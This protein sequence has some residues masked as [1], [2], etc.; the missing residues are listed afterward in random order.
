M[1]SSHARSSMFTL[2]RDITPNYAPWPLNSSFSWMERSADH[3]ILTRFE[4]QD[5][6][7]SSLGRPG[8]IDYHGNPLKR[9][10]RT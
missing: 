1:T 6:I 2:V 4:A 7:R 5:R 8:R 10:K 3:G 9:R